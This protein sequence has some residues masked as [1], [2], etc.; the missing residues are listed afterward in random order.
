MELIVRLHRYGKERKTPTRVIFVPDPVCWTQVPSDYRSLLRQRDRWQ[1]GLIE[2]LM[3]HF[4]MFLNPRYGAIGLI[5]MPFYFFFEAIG[6]V[7]ELLGYILIPILWFFSVL[8]V[9]FAIMFFAMAVLYNIMLSLLA[10][11]VDDLLF[12]RY[13]RASDLG[14]MMLSAFLEFIGYRQIMAVR[15]TAAFF[16]ML[17]RRQHWGRINRS[18]IAEAKAGV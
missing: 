9:S 16:T 18:P 13:D 12:Q 5:G 3:M 15:R 14:K 11:I 17:F 8:D 10:L 7:I 4:R 1:R 6:P 2:S